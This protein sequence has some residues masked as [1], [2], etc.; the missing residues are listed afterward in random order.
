MR[1]CF[2]VVFVQILNSP[3]ELWNVV[4][5]LWILYWVVSKI[6]TLAHMNGASKPP[7]KI[8]VV[9]PALFLA[10]FVID[11]LLQIIV[12]DFRLVSK[13]LEKVFDCNE[14]IIVGV[15]Y[16]ESLSHR[17]KTTPKLGLQEFFKLQNSTFNNFRLLLFVCFELLLLFLLVSLFVWLRFLID[18]V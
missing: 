1:H 5:E 2:H 3:I 7:W 4:F 9:E 6:E 12:V 15:K 10:V 14:S 18:D 17:L 11:K 8:C 13:V 16:K